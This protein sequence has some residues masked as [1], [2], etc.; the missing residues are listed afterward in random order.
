[1]L[2]PSETIH[3]WLCSPSIDPSPHVQA[4]LRQVDRYETAAAQ[5][6]MDWSPDDVDRFLD[7]VDQ[8]RLEFDE[9]D[10]HANVR[11]AVARYIETQVNPCTTDV[12]IRKLPSRLREARQTGTIMYRKEDQKFITMWDSKAG[13]P[14]LCPD[15]AREEAMRVQRRV[16]PAVMEALKQKGARAYYAVFTMPDAAPGKLR[17]AQ[18]SMF[19]RFNSLIR[20]CKR[21]D[22]LPLLGAYGVMESPLSWDRDWH[23]H[24]N[25][26]LVTRGWFDYAKLR[27]LWHWNVEVRRLAS[28]ETAIAAAL[29]EI[30]K[31]SCRAVPE[32]SAS[33]ATQT[34]RHAIGAAKRGADDQGHESPLA[35]HSMALEEQSAAPPALPECVDS[36]TQRRV[37]DAKGESSRDGAPA[38]PGASPPALIE[39]TPQE[40]IEWWNAHKG[41]RR[42]R[43]YGCLFRIDDPEPESMDGF[44][45]VGTVAHDG[46]R[47]VRRFALLGSI[48][49][50]KSSTMSHRERLKAYLRRLTGPPEEHQ[51]A[52]AVM[53]QALQTWPN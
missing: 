19:K 9:E 45:A 4:A 49:G 42:S 36:S 3:R 39:W 53:N 5:H 13:I 31:Y 29:T 48:P 11:L 34:A 35:G 25:V 24:L 16:V 12:A 38:S 52:L 23:V 28:T 8:Q 6:W 37:V 17:A 32:K 10:S 43:G 44:E 7:L 26:I 30:I 1:M 27:H 40:F 18:R 33:K 47:L 20:K 15:D 2:N 41:F 51:R 21:D 46:A 14:L 50:D 22:S